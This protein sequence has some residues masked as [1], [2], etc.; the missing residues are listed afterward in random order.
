MKTTLKQNGNLS[1]GHTQIM[2]APWF[3]LQPSNFLSLVQ[4]N[5]S[6]SNKGN[7]HRRP[8]INQVFLISIKLTEFSEQSDNGGAINYILYNR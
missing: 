5:E 4:K 3:S 8:N 6:N 1:S 2:N 7:M